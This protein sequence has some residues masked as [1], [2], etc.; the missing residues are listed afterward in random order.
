MK[1]RLKQEMEIVHPQL[2][3]M[4]TEPHLL[5]GE[6]AVTLCCYVGTLE[7]LINK[8]EGLSQ[9]SNPITPIICIFIS[10][11]ACCQY[12]TVSIFKH[13]YVSAPK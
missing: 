7:N 3:G 13:P 12:T 1:V 5:V 9:V 6:T 8:V 2:I 10:Q 4:V 11:H